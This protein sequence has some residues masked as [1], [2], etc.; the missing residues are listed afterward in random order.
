[1]FWIKAFLKH[2]CNRL[3]IGVRKKWLRK[4]NLWSDLLQRVKEGKARTFKNANE[5]N[6]FLESLKTEE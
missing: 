3:I 4:D 2:V 5:L 6:A 1:L